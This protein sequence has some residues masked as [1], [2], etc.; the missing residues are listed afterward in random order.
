MIPSRRIAQASVGALL[1]TTVLAAGCG[2]STK[3]TASSTSGS[4]YPMTINVDGTTL[5]FKSR[6]KILVD[7]YEAV[8]PVA[9]AGGDQTK[10]IVGITDDANEP[11]GPAGTTMTSVPR[12]STFTDVSKEVIVGS[13]AKLVITHG[14]DTGLQDQLAPLG[15]QTMMV[16]VCWD[17]YAAAHGGTVGY[18]AIYSDITTIGRLLGTESYATASIASQKQ[19][20]ATVQNEALSLPKESMVMTAGI[21][22]GSFFTYGGSSIANTQVETL[23]QTNAFGSTKQR[24]FSLSPEELV[25]SNPGFIVL[26][27]DPV[28]ETPAKALQEDM[29]VPG[30]ASLPAI[31]SHHYV[32]VSDTYL[33][34]RAID[35]LPIIYNA[36]V[37]AQ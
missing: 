4:S 33:L 2:S 25:A 7:Q 5:T 18:D 13:G 1:A 37:A 30:F 3:S 12:I 31:M 24:G 23:G 36:M 8:F 15:I 19:I 11:L 32:Q 27:Y 21:F 35:G 14:L 17:G 20:V 29:A 6:P 26:G 28:S 16:N 22:S 9:A 10:D 34:G